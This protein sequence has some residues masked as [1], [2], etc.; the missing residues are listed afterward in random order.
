[1][2]SMLAKAKNRGAQA[3]M[4]AARRQDYL[5]SLSFKDRKILKSME[6]APATASGDS[7][8]NSAIKSFL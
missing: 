4:A 6:R 1:M 7:I 5:K 8:D 3:S 2:E